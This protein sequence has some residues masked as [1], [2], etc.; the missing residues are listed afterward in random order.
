MA[1]FY[2]AVGYVVDET[3]DDITVEKPV[4][5]FYKGDVLKRSRRLENSEGINDNV[6]IS[7]QIS[8]IADPY[9]YNHIFAMRY[10]KYLGTAWKVTT[11]EA[12]TP[13]LVLSLGGVYNGEIVET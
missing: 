7:N 13:R 4:E 9:A 12:Q 2:G 8:I 11:V 10:V 3:K 6:T 5:R 1:K